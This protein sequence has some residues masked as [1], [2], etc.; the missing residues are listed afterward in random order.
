M[1]ALHFNCAIS[2]VCQRSGWQWPPTH[3]TQYSS[4][5]TRL[6][7][8]PSSQPLDIAIYAGGQAAGIAGFSALDIAI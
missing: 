5:M 6:G 4:Y 3:T 8:L 2:P 1:P 7:D